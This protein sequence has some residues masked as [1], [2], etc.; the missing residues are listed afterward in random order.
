MVAA[1]EDKYD[2]IWYMLVAWLMLG[3]PF[4][5]P[6]FRGGVCLEF[7][8][9]YMDYCKFE[10]GL[11]ERRTN[12]IVQWV[13]EARRNGGLVTHRSFVELVGRLVYAGQVLV[14]MKPLMAPLHAW[15]GAIAHGTV[16]VLPQTV[17]VILLFIAEMPRKGHHHTSGRSPV[18]GGLQAFR[19]DAKCEEGRVVLGGWELGESANPKSARWFAQEIFPQDAPWLFETKHV[20]SRSTTAE[21][22]ASLTALEIFGFFRKSSRPRRVVVE[23]GTDNLASEHITRKGGAT[24]SPCHMSKCSWA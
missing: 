17:S 24:N 13:E 23:A 5:W 9:F 11:S 3:T 6:K 8:G 10:V 21:L 12:W 19:T 22:L 18:R 20:P 2:Q 4:R 7:V 14:W 1:G 15:K 16:A